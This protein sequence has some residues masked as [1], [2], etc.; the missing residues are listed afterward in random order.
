MNAISRQILELLNDDMVSHGFLVQC[1]D[2]AESHGDQPALSWK[3]V[4]EE[5]L[6]DE[7]EIGAAKSRSLDYVEFIA[8]RGTIDAR[9]SRAVECVDN[10]E[11]SDREFAYWLCLRKNVDRYEGEE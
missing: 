11:P 8:W 6:S 2:E 10:A 9:I 1:V 4:L 5:L 3:D 7:V